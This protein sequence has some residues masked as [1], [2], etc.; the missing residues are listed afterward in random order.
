MDFFSV[1]CVKNTQII[2]V[3]YFFKPFFIKV[4][5]LLW[6]VI[7]SFLNYADFH[8]LTLCNLKI[9][10]ATQY[11]K[12]SLT[13]TETRQLCRFSSINPLQFKNIEYDSI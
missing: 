4:F 6:R 2:Q 1:L 3:Q 11:K 8:P 12:V 5:Q 7:C 10:S 13:K 9:S